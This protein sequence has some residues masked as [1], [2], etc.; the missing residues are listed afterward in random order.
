MNE[1]ISSI[2]IRVMSA[3]SFFKKH[4]KHTKNTENT[5]NKIQKTNTMINF[6]AIFLFFKN[7]IKISHHICKV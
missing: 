2:V 3:P 6:S 7:K 5:E 4:K 1:I